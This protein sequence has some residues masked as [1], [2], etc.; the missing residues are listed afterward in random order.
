[1]LEF[2]GIISNRNPAIDQAKRILKNEMGVSSQNGVRA[3]EADMPLRAFFAQHI[4]QVGI[5]ITKILAGAYPHAIRRIGDDP[6]L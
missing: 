2:R 3:Q 6:T 5:E 4:P 1:M